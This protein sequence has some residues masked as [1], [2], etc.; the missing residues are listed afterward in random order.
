MRKA[1]YHFNSDTLSF[2]KIESSLRKKLWRLFKKFFSSFSLAIVMLYLV[3]AF[4]DSPK[5]KLLKRKYEEVLTQYSLLSNKVGHLDN[6]L[7]D[8]EARDDNIYRVIFETD[9]IPSSIR[10]AGSG[11]VDQYEHLRQ[12]DNADL[13]IGT[14]K[15]IDEKSKAIYIQSKSFDKIEE[16]AKNKIDMLASIPAIL[17]VSLK[18]KS[19]H[20][21]TSSFGY[22]MHP[23]Y[24]TPKFHAGM[25]FT[26]TVGT[27]ICATGKVNLTRD[28]VATWSS[29]TG[30]ATKHCMPTWIKSW[31]KKA[32]KSNE[33]TSSDTWETPDYPRVLTCIMKYGKITN[34]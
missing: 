24:K 11:G 18:N 12:I 22:R 19:T 13:L 34:R 3:Y 4:I 31:L 17:P 27:P 30:S 15:K 32:K 2:D 29:T 25:D 6:V 9:P 8:M 28:T 1:G 20:Q 23:I 14:A 33:G 10:R 16:L 5:E 7:K 21:V 26:G